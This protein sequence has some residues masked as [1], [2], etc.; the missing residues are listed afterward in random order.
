MPCGR[1]VKQH[2]AHYFIGSVECYQV[3]Y[4]DGSIATKDGIRVY[5]ALT[6]DAYYSCSQL[7][8]DAIKF[9]TKEEIIQK[10]KDWDGMPWWYKFKPDSLI[11]EEVNSSTTITCDTEYRKVY[12]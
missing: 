10:W 12:P 6:E 2:D 8:A 1:V 7:K 3:K 9:K 11:I 5:L 4:C